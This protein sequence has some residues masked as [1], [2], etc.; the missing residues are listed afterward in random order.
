MLAVL[1]MGQGFT[2]NLD[3]GAR[4]LGLVFVLLVVLACCEIIFGSKDK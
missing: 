4:L 3:A 1:L 2:P